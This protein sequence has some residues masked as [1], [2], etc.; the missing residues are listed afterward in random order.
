MKRK[1]TSLVLLPSRLIDELKNSYLLLDTCV[2]YDAYKYGEVFT[3]F[4]DSLKKERC[5]LLTIFPVVVEFSRNSDTIKEY[6]SR[7]EFIKTIV[8]VVLPIERT[9]IKDVEELVL[10]YRN[11]GK[12]TSLTDFFLAG[13]LKRYRGL[14]LMT[15]NNKDFPIEIFD[16]RGIICNDAGQE[17][18]FYGI[19]KFSEEKHSSVLKRLLEIDE[20]AK[21]SRLNL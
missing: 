10:A 16:R 12:H 14:F 19:Y 20:K 4:F 3:T 15:R 18:Q 9:L 11:H 2:F 8:G 13:T 17:P 21:K 1:T 6:K 5:V 7:R